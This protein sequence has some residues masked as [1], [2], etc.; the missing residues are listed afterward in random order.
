M[1]DAARLAR[2]DARTLNAAAAG[3]RDAGGRGR[4]AWRTATLGFQGLRRGLVADRGVYRS[5]GNVNVQHPTNLSSVYSGLMSAT[6]DLLEL[7]RVV[8]QSARD[9]DRLLNE[10]LEP[11]ARLTV[12]DLSVLHAIDVGVAYPTDIAVRLNQA[13]PTVS[14]VISRLVARGLIERARVDDDGRKRRLTLTE[15]GQVALDRSRQ[16]IESGLSDGRYKLTDKDIVRT[17]K[18]LEKYMKIMRFGG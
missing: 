3:D 9:T 16:V 5:S 15:T 12:Q 10:W 14:H 13:S 18:A 4:D 11:E 7:F 2:L 8:L 17:Q 6:S 1:R